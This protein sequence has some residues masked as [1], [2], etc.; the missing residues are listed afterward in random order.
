MTMTYIDTIA[1]FFHP[2]RD[3]A[4]WAD[5]V[6]EAALATPRAE[7]ELAAAIADEAVEAAGGGDEDVNAAARAIREQMPAGRMRTAIRADLRPARH[8]AQCEPYWSARRA[9]IACMDG[10]LS[11]AIHALAAI[12]E[13]DSSR[14][15]R[16][17]ATVVSESISRPSFPEHWEELRREVKL[18]QL[19]TAHSAEPEDRCAAANRGWLALLEHGEPEGAYLTVTR[20]VSPYYACLA[21]GFEDEHADGRAARIPLPV[22]LETLEGIEYVHEILTGLRAGQLDMHEDQDPSEREPCDPDELPSAVEAEVRVNDS[23]RH[24]EL[25]RTSKEQD[26]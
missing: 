23:I 4:A 17:L 2:R 3:G 13:V 1:Y 11:G 18:A 5:A 14:L 15:A 12:R 6:E 25:A 9:L 16:R 26:R 8:L 19:A 7:A 22:F 24:L 10:D 21:I 20:D